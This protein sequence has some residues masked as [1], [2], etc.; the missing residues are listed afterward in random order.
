[1]EDVSFGDV[2]LGTHRTGVTAVDLNEFEK[3]SLLANA[4]IYEGQQHWLHYRHIEQE[5][6]QF[7]GFFFTLLVAIVGFFVAI[8]SRGSSWP[9]LATGL[10]VMA[11]VLGTICLLIFASVRKFGA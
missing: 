1:M 7:L 2:I 3:E 5:R 8:S 9:T 4:L 10:T 11:A 6:N